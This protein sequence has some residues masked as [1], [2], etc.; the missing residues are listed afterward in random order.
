MNNNLCLNCGRAPQFEESLCEKCF[1]K[2]KEKYPN[3]PIRK[4]KKWK[5]T[6]HILYNLMMEKSCSTSDLAK[7][8]GVSERSVLKWIFE[9]AIPN[10]NNA[11]VAADFF[12]MKPGQLFPTHSTF[13]SEETT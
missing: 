5:I 13:D 8:V 1:I 9:N 2:K 3:R 4:L 6:N 11:K 12:G 7:H 10:E